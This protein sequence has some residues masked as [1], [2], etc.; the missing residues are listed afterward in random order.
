MRKILR[1]TAASPG[2]GVGRVQLYRAAKIGALDRKVKDRDVELERYRLAVERFCA[3]L[4]KKADHVAAVTGQEQADILLSQ[5]VMVRD[6]YLT[7]Q[8]E[9]RISAFQPVEYALNAACETFIRE[10][11]AAES[12][13]TR[14]RA[15]DIQDLRDGLLRILLDLPEADFS[16]IVPN[17]IL[18]AEEL[19]PS[20]MT[21]LDSKALAGI[22]L[23]RGGRA[24]HTAILAR[25]MEIPTVVGVAGAAPQVKN[26]EWAVV[27]GSRGLVLL[28][29][30][31]EELAQSRS[32]QAEYLR[33]RETLKKCA[34]RATVTADGFPVRLSATV[35]SE[36]EILLAEEY[37]CD[38]IGLV[39]SEFL[40]LNRPSLPEEEQQFQT[41]R[42]LAQRAGGKPVTIR[43]LDI[44]GDKELPGFSQEREENPFLGCR[45]IRFC[46]REEELFRTQL[47]AVLRAG[48]YGDVRLLLPLL[49]G[50]EELRRVRSILEGCKQE[51]RDSGEKFRE[52]MPVGVMMETAAATFVAEL[53]A[54]EAD[55][56]SIG[57]NDLTQYTLAVDR[58]NAMVSPLY[59]YYHPALLRSVRRIVSCG[60]EAGIPVGVCGQAVADPLFIPLLLA[61]GLDEFSVEPSLLLSVRRTF[62]LW[63]LGEAKALA[64]EALTLETEEEVHRLLEKNH[65]EL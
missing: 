29:P 4:Q 30:S 34:G 23:C 26:G 61:L 11:Q 52:E 33:D 38:G 22:V 14:L 13:M 60:R 35:G 19:P 7:G 8:V 31:E 12:E 17:A 54:R 25:A 2:I 51:L 56:F 18:V 57:L 43:T 59:S 36:S 50:V 20:A 62:S 27:D 53:L 3:Q 21:T 16:A 41:Y 45:A 48:A 39:R 24:S 5:I 15:A 28:S 42:R 46:L 9:G 10:F 63:T 37:G 44:G 1:G 47:K 40:Y 64:E 32:R 6:P 49:T 58:D 55:F 65:R